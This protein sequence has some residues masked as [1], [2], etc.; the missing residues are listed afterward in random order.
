MV[1]HDLNQ[2]AFPTLD[3]ALLAV[4]DQLV[5]LIR[6][7]AGHPERSQHALPRLIFPGEPGSSQADD[8]HDERAAQ[9]IRRAGDG[10]QAIAE[11]VAEARERAEP[12][13][14][15]G[16]GPE[17]EREHAHAEHSR[18][19]RRAKTS[20]RRSTPSTTSRCE[21][22]ARSCAMGAEFAPG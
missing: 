7:D 22:G 10:L 19:R 1:V 17:Q 3:A 20:C 14:G 9:L 5:E 6:S 8:D 4:H 13:Q 11:H 15:A 18:E 16:A 21:T 2:I 12:E